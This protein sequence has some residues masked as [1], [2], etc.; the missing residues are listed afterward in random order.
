MPRS[1][2]QTALWF[3]SRN[4]RHYLE[5]ARQLV[6]FTLIRFTLEY[7][8]TVWDPYYVKDIDRLE[9]VNQRAVCILKGLSLRDREVSSTALLEDLKW[10]TLEER[11]KD[12]RLILMYK[13]VNGLITMLATVLKPTSGHT[14][15]NHQFKYQTISTNCDPSK[16]SYFPRT[17]PEWN[18][19]KSDIVNCPSVN[20]FKTGLF[21]P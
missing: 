14:R 7:S 15:A 21:K 5:S 18:N 13:I 17:I 11:R 12:L 2:K 10:K 20:A 8:C 9:M 4:L 1:A 16:Y 19:L 3:I 6:Y